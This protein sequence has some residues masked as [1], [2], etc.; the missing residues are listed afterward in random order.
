MNTKTILIVIVI[1]IAIA[2]AW[3]LVSPAFIVKELDEISPL[4]VKD[5]MLTM[6]AATKAEFEQQVEKMKEIEVVSSE[7]MPS[8]P[9][10]IARGE[11]MPV[12]MM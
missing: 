10:V 8:Q 2:A 11:F 1:L 6:D 5:A 4:E 3:Y 9:K 7:E 12:H